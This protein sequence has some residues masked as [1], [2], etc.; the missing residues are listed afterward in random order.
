MSRV[1]YDMQRRLVTVPRSEQSPTQLTLKEFLQT[2]DCP[3]PWAAERCYAN[4]NKQTGKRVLEDVPL[5]AVFSVVDEENP[6]CLMPFETRCARMGLPANAGGWSRQDTMVRDLFWHDGRAPPEGSDAWRYVRGVARWQEGDQPREGLFW[7]PVAPSVAPHQQDRAE[8]PKH[9]DPRG[10]AG[11]GIV[12][13]PRAT[14]RGVGLRYAQ[15]W[16]VSQTLK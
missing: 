5:G 6:H 8:F 1:H 2:A 11:T 13:Y 4:M 12:Y 10:F 14:A 9:L 3:T 7:S 16:P 15:A